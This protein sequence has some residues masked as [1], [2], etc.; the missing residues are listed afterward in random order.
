ME[1]RKEEYGIINK[2]LIQLLEQSREVI[3]EGFYHSSC[4]TK[5][6]HKVIIVISLPFL[7]LPQCVT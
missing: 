3:M 6:R 5:F 4:V 1:T 2:E 7:N